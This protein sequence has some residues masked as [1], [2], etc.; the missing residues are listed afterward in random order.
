[1]VACTM[2][3][4]RPVLASP[5]IVVTQERPRVTLRCVNDLC[6]L[7]LLEVYRGGR[8]RALHPIDYYQRQRAIVATCPACGVER[9]WE[10]R[11]DR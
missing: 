3:A 11:G 7:P 8:L 9:R 2:T 4:D 5:P 1:M 10:D 6:K